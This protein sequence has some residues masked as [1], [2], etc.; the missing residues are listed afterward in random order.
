MIS[1]QKKNDNALK[2]LFKNHCSISSLISSSPFPLSNQLQSPIHCLSSTSLKSVPFS[3][4]A[5]KCRPSWLSIE[6][7]KQPPGRLPIFKVAFSIHPQPP[8][9]CEPESPKQTSIYFTPL[10]TNENQGWAPL[11]AWKA[12]PDLASAF[13]FISHLLPPM[14][15]TTN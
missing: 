13:Y 10:H 9:A 4:E 3:F 12:F 2:T 7:I 8:P 14:D 11:L 15:H 6:T 1:S 5:S